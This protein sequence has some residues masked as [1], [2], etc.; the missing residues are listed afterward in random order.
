M[1]IQELINKTFKITEE[2][3]SF[4]MKQMH[5]FRWIYLSVDRIFHYYYTG[6]KL[7]KIALPLGSGRRQINSEQ[8]G[9]I[10]GNHRLDSKSSINSIKL[11]LNLFGRY[12]CI[13]YI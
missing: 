7:R 5:T 8:K 13:V 10:P 4:Q 6:R 9:A 1:H 2:I 11:W 3:E 12:K